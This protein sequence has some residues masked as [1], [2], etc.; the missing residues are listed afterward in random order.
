M[1]LF[2][3]HFV[4][5]LFILSS[6]VFLLQ[7]PVADNLPMGKIWIISGLLVGLH[8]LKDVILDYVGNKKVAKKLNIF[9][10]VIVILIIVK[11]VL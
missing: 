9:A 10:M 6:F 8:E 11:V 4:N 1:A 3:K 2:K 5:I 7:I